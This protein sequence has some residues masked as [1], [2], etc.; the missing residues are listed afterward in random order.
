MLALMLV[1]VFSESIGK[2]I[3]LI[4]PCISEVLEGGRCESNV[5]AQML[6]LEMVMNAACA[7]PTQGIFSL[8][9]H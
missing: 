6:R 8:Q 1:I 9:A 2:E 7:E 4:L 3:M 5:S